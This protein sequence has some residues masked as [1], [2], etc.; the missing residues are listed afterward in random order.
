MKTIVLYIA[1][2]HIAVL[3]TQPVFGQKNKKNDWYEENLKGKVVQI[4]SKTYNANLKFGEIAKGDCKAESKVWFNENGFIIRR[5]DTDAEGTTLRIYDYDAQ[6]DLCRAMT[7][8]L[9]SSTTDGITVQKR[10]TTAITT[11]EY[12]YDANG[13]LKEQNDYDAD[14]NLTQKIKHSYLQGTQTVTTYDG[15]GELKTHVTVTD[16]GRKRVT[17]S[18]NGE[19][20]EAIYDDR[21]R[22]ITIS[23]P[24]SNIQGQR[25]DQKQHYKYNNQ[26]DLA[27][28]AAAENVNGAQGNSLVE[29]EYEYDKQ[30]NWIVRKGYSQST[31]RGSITVDNPLKVTLDERVIIYANSDQDFQAAIKQEEQE[32][33]KNEERIALLQHRADSIARVQEHRADSIARVQDSIRRIEYENRRKQQELRECIN[34][35]KKVAERVFQISGSSSASILTLNKT[36]NKVKEVSVVGDSV[37]FALKSNHIGPLTFI[38]QYSWTPQSYLDAIAYISTDRKH[39]VIH[40]TLKDGV[41]FNKAAI[42]VCTESGMIYEIPGKLRKL[43]LEHMQ[44]KDMESLW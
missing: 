28:I 11:Y 33:R 19:Q 31:Y 40:C 22:L 12:I 15:N 14:G 25:L 8:K 30:G 27:S 10:D 5:Q 43:F 41:L 17:P 38:Q 4:T 34:S 23:V 6:G 35:L 44:L 21:G 18:T 39:A 24:F 20:I 32:E 3:L 16:G 26:G 9:T 2:V 37:L 13:R 7:I 42:L 29:Y 1:T 36:Y